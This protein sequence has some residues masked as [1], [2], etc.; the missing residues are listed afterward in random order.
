V[1]LNKKTEKDKTVVERRFPFKV[2]LYWYWRLR[3][4]DALFAGL[5]ST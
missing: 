3:R 1:F 5:E 2:I 4:P